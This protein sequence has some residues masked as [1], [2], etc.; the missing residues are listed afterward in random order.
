MFERWILVCFRGNVISMTTTRD[1]WSIEA[2]WRAWPLRDPSQCWSSHPSE[3]TR[4]F[5][6]TKL[7]SQNP[8]KDA[9]WK[10][11]PTRFKWT[12]ILHTRWCQMKTGD[13]S[14]SWQRPSCLSS[15]VLCSAHFRCCKR[16]TWT[17]S[18]RALELLVSS[19][20]WNYCVYTSQ[21]GGADW[22]TYSIFTDHYLVW[23]MFMFFKATISNQERKCYV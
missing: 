20:P 7:W 9:F 2:K 11:R 8:D 19:L 23:T 5:K 4:T 22:C 14:S 6:M 13:G 21:V 12:T 3:F 16:P 18:T 17:I 15:S 10:H 1:G